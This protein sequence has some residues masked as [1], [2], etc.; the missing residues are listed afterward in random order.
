MADI[1]ATLG[2]DPSE[3]QALEGSAGRTVVPGETGSSDALRGL[4]ALTQFGGGLVDAMSSIGQ[5]NAQFLKLDAKSA[6]DQAKVD[7][8]AYVGL[9]TKAFADTIL[10]EDTESL[11]KVYGEVAR[12]DK[13]TAQGAQRS[14]V[15]RRRIELYKQFVSEKPHLAD[16]ITD[17][18]NKNK[19]LESLFQNQ[20]TSTEAA[21]RERDEK[22]VSAMAESLRAKGVADP[23][24]KTPVEIRSL[25]ATHVQP[26]IANLAAVE[27]SLK[28]IQGQT[29]ITDLKKKEMV[30]AK[31]PEV[32]DKAIQAYNIEANSIKAN[33]TL[34]ADQKVAAMVELN[35]QTQGRLASAF[36][37]TM[38]D[39]QI[40]SNFSDLFG[41]MEDNMK[42][43][44]GE[45]KGASLKTVEYDQKLK[46]ALAAA[47]I[48][49]E[50]GPEA[51]RIN[52][53]SNAWASTLKFLPESVTNELIGVPAMNIAADMKSM[54]SGVKSSRGISGGNMTKDPKAIRFEVVPEVEH[55]RSVLSQGQGKVPQEAVDF[56]VYRMSSM[57]NDPINGKSAVIMDTLIPV[58]ADKKVVEAMNKSSFATFVGEQGLSRV[59]GYLKQVM[60][61]ADRQLQGFAKDVT[62]TEGEDGLPIFKVNP[63]A[64]VDQSVLSRAQQRLHDSAKA[65][66]HLNNSNDYRAS[67]LQ[68]MQDR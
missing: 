48:R 58:L 2:G 64:R 59:S 23:T 21:Q 6:A 39:D 28:I 38:G 15:Q 55:I 8:A 31:V 34:S 42:I 52:A 50:M 45:F 29:N 13:A 66:A 46:D 17:A 61:A 20:E 57:L 1:R 37:G 68:L 25:Y 9:A 40:R 51:N 60:G 67:M 18:F 41:T 24:G 12:L 3:I 43:V 54:M 36:R 22:A 10:P 44:T 30:A 19:T 4:A 56:A 53:F 49:Q 32:G 62:I 5:T 33:S 35:R 63:G 11:V 16:K 27:D 26:V 65:Y 47:N 7:E 14:M